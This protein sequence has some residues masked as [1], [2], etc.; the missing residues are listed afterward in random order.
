LF[1]G[2]AR[3]VHDRVFQRYRWIPPS[4]R[5]RLIEPAVS[6]GSA[7]T[8]LPTLRQ[9]ASYIRRSSLPVPDRYFSYS[10]ISSL[11]AADLFMVDFLE[12]ANGDDALAAARN[13]FFAARAKSDLNRWLYVDLKITITDGDL[14]KVT[15]MS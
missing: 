7:W 9:A 14:R 6:A 4:I 12:A 5:Q 15:C 10:L 8:S 11:P 13:H 3:Y 2:N 1:G